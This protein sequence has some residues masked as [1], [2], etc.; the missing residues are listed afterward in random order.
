MK[1]TCFSLLALLAF[2]LPLYSVYGNEDENAGVNEN[3]PIY[4]TVL[5]DNNNQLRR[6]TAETVAEFL[7]QNWIE[8]APHDLVTPALDSPLYHGMRITIERGFTI[9]VHIHNRLFVERHT[10]GVSPGTRVFQL[11]QN[12]SEEMDREFLWDETIWGWPVTPDMELELH[13][14]LVLH[15][16]RNEE[17]PYG[18]DYFYTY[19]LPQD[20]RTIVSE[21]LS[22]TIFIT[23]EVR[24]LVG[25]EIS[26]TRISEEITLEP[27]NE[28]MA[29]GT[30]PPG[31]TIPESLQSII[32]PVGEPL[33]QPLPERPVV[34]VR[35]SFY[36][37]GGVPI[38]IGEPG[39]TTS[40]GF[41]VFTGTYL[42]PGNPGETF[43]VVDNYIIVDGIAFE[44][45]RMMDMSATAY[46]A[47]FASTGRHPGDRLFGITASGL[48]A[49]VGVVAVDTS[50]IPFFTLLYIEGYGFA[51]AGDRGSAVRG[52][53]IDL[54][55]DTAAE[56]RQFGRRQRYVFILANQDI[57]LAIY[58]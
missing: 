39:E 4:V 23:E 41:Q 51:I 14:V 18:R 48:T 20:Y 45:T 8:T 24:Y 35:H 40:S 29:V 54:F 1:K 26:R 52:Y 19:N 31:Q 2:L 37:G 33:P 58:R 11:I 6:T 17:L 38:F 53:I 36:L 49:Q 56:A 7:A 10:V 30:G 32:R 12:L 43:Y 5:F 47:D 22:G 21:G 55:F 44:F 34:D 50:V 15:V 3:R 16:A 13:E 27:I 28:I 25:E 46:T 57:E 42:L 9:T